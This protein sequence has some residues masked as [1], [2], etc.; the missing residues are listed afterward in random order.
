MNFGVLHYLRTLTDRVEDFF[1]NMCLKT[2]A[3]SI[4]SHNVC[5]F[6][7][8]QADTVKK[9]GMV[10]FKIY[11]FLKNVSKYCLIVMIS[12]KGLNIKIIQL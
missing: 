6:Q 5:Q 3:R 7:F 10:I 4:N 8:G 2:A 9:N 11:F 12:N 1:R